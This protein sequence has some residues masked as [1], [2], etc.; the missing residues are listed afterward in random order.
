MVVVVVVALNSCGQRYGVV[1]TMRDAL[2][3]SH[4]V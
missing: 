2:I 3:P 4:G 1:L